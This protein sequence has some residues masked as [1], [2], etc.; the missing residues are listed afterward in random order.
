V[1]DELRS[2]GFI[3]L[4]LHGDLE[5]RERDQTL[6]QFSNKSVSVLVATDVAARGLDIDA[7]DAVINYEIAH[8]PEIH[9]HRIGRTGRAGSRGVACSLFSDGE[10][11]KVALLEGDVDPILDHE[12]LPSPSVLQAEV[13]Q[14]AMATL[15]IDAGKKQKIRPGDIL[16]ALTG[17]DGVLGAD[18]GKIA[19]FDNM[20][21]VAVRQ[22]VARVASRKLGRGKLKGRS[23][24]ARLIRD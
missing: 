12:P 14:P 6:V 1:T 17:E 4:A 10:R 22:G 16:G 9:L 8:D 7:L 24:R 3:A 19:I 2:H 13:M 11:H 23:V 21:F 15:H 20:A 5:Q 18:V